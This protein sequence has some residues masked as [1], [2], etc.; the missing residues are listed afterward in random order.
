MSE[1][2]QNNGL[3]QDIG[4]RLWIMVKHSE[5]VKQE[6]LGRIVGMMLDWFQ[7]KGNLTIQETSG[8]K[9]ETFVE[10]M[11][12]TFLSECTD[13]LIRYRTSTLG[14][15][16]DQTQTIQQYLLS[17]NQKYTAIFSSLRNRQTEEK[18]SISSEF[19]KMR[20]WLTDTEISEKIGKL[21]DVLTSNTPYCIE[22]RLARA[23]N[24]DS[25]NHNNN[26]RRL[27]DTLKKQNEDVVVKKIRDE[28]S[29]DILS[30]NKEKLFIHGDIREIRPKYRHVMIKVTEKILGLGDDT[31]SQ[32]LQAI[33]DIMD[34]KRRLL[35]MTMRGVQSF[36]GVNGI[37]ST[38]Y[39]KMEMYIREREKDMDKLE[40]DPESFRKALCEDFG[41]VSAVLKRQIELIE[42][43]Q[44]KIASNGD[45]IDADEIQEYLIE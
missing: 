16:H 39:K 37:S 25:Q 10:T 3:Y 35:S 15:V 43:G 41:L 2:D 45:D 30:W 44:K 12:P 18:I 1:Y 22:T 34:L 36:G 6:D 32:E 40:N 31:E 26:T 42:D 7:S 9:W 21:E 38:Q 28:Y 27:I 33:S 20:W 29:H 8:L 24:M 11:F 23:K 14:L 5:Q 13:K 19:L 17:H 4:N